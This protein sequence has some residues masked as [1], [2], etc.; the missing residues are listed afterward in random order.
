MP[1][2]EFLEA[3]DGHP[4]GAQVDLRISYGESLVARN[5]CKWVTSNAAT[6]LFSQDMDGT[7]S[8]PTA[9]DIAG[10]FVLQANNDWVDPKTAFETSAGFTEGSVIFAGPGGALT[11]DNDQFFFDDAN[12]RLGVGTD[13]PNARLH[14]EQDMTVQPGVEI[15]RSGVDATESLLFVGAAGSTPDLAVWG[16]GRVAI[17][18]AQTTTNAALRVR[19]N[20]SGHAAAL[21]VDS[22]QSGVVGIELDHEGTTS[23]AVQISTAATT[24]T[25]LDLQGDSLTSGRIAYFRSSSSSVVSRRLVEILNGNASADNTDCLRIQQNADGK[26]DRCVN[27]SSAIVHARAVDGS[28]QAKP[29]DTNTDVQPQHEDTSAKKMSLQW[30]NSAPTNAAYL[31]FSNPPGTTD[32]YL[33]L[34]EGE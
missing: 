27:V 3:Y 18:E 21:F 2:F 9:A 1:L 5:I 8:G 26:I 22:D 10:N 23:D 30:R 13:T 20:D 32:I 19:S 7:V 4:Q 6:D 28:W 24:A 25:G 31:Q 17:G 14:I 33:V 29:L 16:D 11:E 12:E 34:E 15:R